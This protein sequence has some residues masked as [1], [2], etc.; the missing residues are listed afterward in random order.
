M[1]NDYDTAYHRSYGE[2]T[3]KL[4]ERW[5]KEIA[6]TAMLPI[7]IRTELSPK[8]NAKIWKILYGLQP[9]H[10][11]GSESDTNL[12]THTIATRAPQNAYQ[13]A[14]K[15]DYKKSKKTSATRDIPHSYC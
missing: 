9:S 7:H 3:S 5:K 10:D 15:D 13:S 4:A 12:T 2:F 11:Y 1:K 14:K 6:R 8:R